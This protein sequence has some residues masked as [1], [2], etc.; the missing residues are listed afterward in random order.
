MSTDLKTLLS[1]PDV[2][3]EPLPAEDEDEDE[4]VGTGSTKKSFNAKVLALI[5]LGTLGQAG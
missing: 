2:G 4:T 3:D 1:P 5:G